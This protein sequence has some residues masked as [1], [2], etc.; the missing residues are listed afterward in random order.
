MKVKSSKRRLG[1]TAKKTIELTIM[2][3]PGAAL[4]LLIRY[5][6]M[7]GLVMAFKN[8]HSNG[9]GFFSSLASSKWSGFQNFKFMFQS[10]DLLVA[11]RNTLLYNIVWIILGLVIS[12]AV[13]IILNEITNK[14]TAKLYQTAM[15]FPY[16]L[17]WVVAASFFFAFLSHER[18][19][20]NSMLALFGKQ[21]VM[22]YSETKY[23]PFI[24]TFANLWKGIGYNSVIYLAAICGIDR[25]LYEA[26]AI[27]GAG[28]WKQIKYMTIPMLKPMMFILL[29]MSI[30]RIMSADFGLFW[31]VPMAESSGTLKPVISV[32][33]TY[34]YTAMTDLN[35]FGMSTAAGLSQSVVGF[36]LIMLA[37]TTVRKFNEDYSLF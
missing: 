33:D 27:D 28:K 7:V 29:I 36:I 31:N 22:W 11:I 30:G 35:D 37:N 19:L 25:S 16:F 20:I 15:F 21:P 23:W 18:G 2:A 32:V 12:V 26:A 1:G 5:F 24:L 17:S 6:P 13:A 9:Q 3:L 34:V 8:Y 14:K 4:F 10:S